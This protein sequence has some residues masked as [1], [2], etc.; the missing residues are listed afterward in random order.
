MIDRGP[1]EIYTGDRDDAETVPRAT[2]AQKPKGGMR[3]EDIFG[4]CPSDTFDG[5]EEA[6]RALRRGFAPEEPLS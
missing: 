6:I 5:F 4:R 2:A 3:A 1:I